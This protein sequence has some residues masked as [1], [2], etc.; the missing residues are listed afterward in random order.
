MQFTSIFAAALVATVASA[1]AIVPTLPA[2]A[3]RI[4]VRDTCSD[5]FSSCQYQDG[6]ECVY[7]YSACLQKFGCSGAAG[8]ADCLGTALGCAI[9]CP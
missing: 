5:P 4:V 2:D 1:R 8:G 7:G 9:A 6:N 3:A